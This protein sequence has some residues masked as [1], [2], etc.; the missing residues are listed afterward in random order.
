M[1]QILLAYGLPKET[2]SA[3][4][5]LFKNTKVSLL[6]GWTHRLLW[7][8][9]RCAARGYMSPM[10]VYYLPKQHALN[11]GR[12]NE[13]K[14]LYA[15]KGKKQKIH[16]PRPNPCCIVD[17]GGI[18]LHVNSDKTEFMCFHEKADISTLNDR[19]LKLV[20]MFTYLRSSISSTEND[21]NSRLAKA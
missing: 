14:W 13:R 21:I 9:R 20:D 16:L 8:C 17:A 15:D 1:K 7:H 5:M 4:M 6:T 2:I 3:I 10:P 18:N 19:S 11:V 12:F